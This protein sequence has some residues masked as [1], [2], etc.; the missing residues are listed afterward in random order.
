MTGM[1]NM[2]ITM[3]TDMTTMSSMTITMETGMA[4]MTSMTAITG[5]GTAT[6]TKQRFSFLFEPPRAAWRINM[7]HYHY[8]QEMHGMIRHIRPLVDCG[9]KGD[10]YADAI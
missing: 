3:G 4:A 6:I 5:M 9:K 7:H 1:E 2:T 8:M 10:I